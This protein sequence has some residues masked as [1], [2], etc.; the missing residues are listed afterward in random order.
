MIQHFLKTL[1]LFFQKGEL[2]GEKPT[3][4]LLEERRTRLYFR[5]FFPFNR[6]RARIMGGGGRGE[7]HTLWQVMNTIINNSSME[8]VQ[9]QQF[10]FIQERRVVCLTCF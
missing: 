1:N 4:L 5:Y 9:Q 10:S 7:K 2:G 6:Y 3:S 8:H